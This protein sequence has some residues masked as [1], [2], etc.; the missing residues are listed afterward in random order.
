MSS[1]S[2]VANVIDEAKSYLLGNDREELN[3]LAAALNASGQTTSTGV[4]FNT[5]LGGIRTRA[6]LEI[7][8]EIAYVTAVNQSA[9][10]VSLIDGYKGTTAAN[11]LINSQVIVNPRFY[12]H[13]MINDLNAELDSLSSPSAGLFQIGTADL[14]YISATRGYNIDA[15]NIIDLIDVQAAAATGV[16]GDWRTVRKYKL[17]RSL[18]TT[19][20]GGV[21]AGAAIM[22][23]YAVASGFPLRVTYKKNF[24]AVPADT[25]TTALSTT[26]LPT[27]CYDILAM[28]IAIRQNMAREVSRNTT[29]AEP[30]PRRA[31]EVPPGAVLNST[32]GLQQ[33]YQ[34]RLQEEVARLHAL[35]P[36]RTKRLDA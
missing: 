17:V 12:K 13:Q 16:T 34:A 35:Y 30:D 27:S 23:D 32:R 1:L 15:T 29:D 36:M 11:H 22:I 33:K 7:D 5:A 31:Q 19:G 3:T 21:A 25:L 8:T 9:S 18:P 10:S 24:T 2:T 14:T 20:T 4:T 6:E 26:G 28:G